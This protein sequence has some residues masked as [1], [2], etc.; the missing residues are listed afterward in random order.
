MA[1]IFDEARRWT[2]ISCLGAYFLSMAMIYQMSPFFQIYAKETCGASEATVG[3]IFAVMPSACFLGNFGMDRMISRLGVET[4]LNVG[5]ALLAFSS[6]GF[7]LARTVQGWLFWRVLQGFATAPIYTSISTRLARSYTGNGEFH[8][9]VGIQEML[10]N[11]GV[12]IAPLLGGVVVTL[13]LCPGSSN[14]YKM[15]P[16]L[17]RAKREGLWGFLLIGL[18]LAL[19]T[20]IHS[21]TAS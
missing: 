14:S 21:R 7:G 5:L 3:L 16:L 12:T 17:R 19:T 15:L 18:W 13:C 10:G 20:Y 4:T 9:V 2:L 8:Q 11:S 1:A 6:L